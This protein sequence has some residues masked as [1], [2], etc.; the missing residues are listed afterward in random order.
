MADHDT[1]PGG[2][3]DS[4]TSLGG[5]PGESFTPNPH[6]LNRQREKS[7]TGSAQSTITP[8][9]SLAAARMAAASGFAAQGSIAAAAVNIAARN[10][11]ISELLGKQISAISAG[12]AFPVTEALNNAIGQN[13]F[14]NLDWAKDIGS[15][16]S[17]RI[18]AAESLLTSIA[19]LTSGVALGFGFSSTAANLISSINTN[20]WLGRAISSETEF[21]AP[22]VPPSAYSDDFTSAA[23]YFG[24]HDRTINSFA[25]LSTAIITLIG[26]NRGTRNIGT[27][28]HANDQHR[29][30]WSPMPPLS[31]D[32][33]SRQLSLTSDSRGKC[34]Y[35]Q[36]TIFGSGVALPSWKEANHD[37]RS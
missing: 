9:N 1:V 26:K 8:Q 14:A 11:E 21:K 16:S 31:L 22:P 6:R 4:T 2:D 18:A 7:A 37:R 13:V 3:D 28:S 23:D 30:G 12:I 15:L 32:L 17:L 33:D 20:T 34:C 24:E 36:G 27:K 10:A 35:G 5:N 25:E 29:L 19:P